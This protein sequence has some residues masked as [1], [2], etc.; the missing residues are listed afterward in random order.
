MN[1][2]QCAGIQEQAFLLQL[3]GATSNRMAVLD[4][5]GTILFVNRSWEEY[6]CRKGSPDPG[7]RV[8]ANYVQAGASSGPFAVHGRTAALGIGRV[9]SG[10]S[11]RFSMEYPCPGSKREQ[12]WFL[13][14]VDGLTLP[15]GS[16]G[17]VVSH[18]DISQ[19][20][21]AEG[22][23]LQ[24]K[25]LLQS[26][27]DAIGDGIL[28][29]DLDLRILSVNRTLR[30]WFHWEEDVRGRR[31]HEAIYGRL[32][33]C[34]SCPSLKAGK[35]GA[36]ETDLK[37]DIPGWFRG[38]L[39]VRSTPL[40]DEQGRVC[41]YVEHLRDV[42]SRKEHED[43][44]HEYARALEGSDELIAAVDRNHVYTMANRAYLRN[45][46]LSPQD[47]VGKS[48]VEVLG[49]ETYEGRVKAELDRAFEGQTVEYE[50]EQPLPES[51]VRHMRVRYYPLT[52]ERGHVE[53]VVGV[54]QDVTERKIAEQA[55]RDRHEL[56]RSLFHK[57][58]SV[59]LLIDPETGVVVDGN[60]AAV[61][62]Y[63]YLPEQLKTLKITDLNI[64]SPD[65]LYEEMQ[66]ARTEKRTHFLFR[67]RLSGGQV[68]DVEVYSGPVIIN[69]RELL[70]SI[71]HDV[72]ERSRAQWE[73]HQ[74]H[75]QLEERV[76]E[77]TRELEKASRAKSEFLA[78]MSHEIRTPIAG[79]LGLTEVALGRDMPK[80]NRGEMVMVR[81]SA[82]SLLHIVNDILD[83]SKIEAR[84]MELDLRNFNL[85]VLLRKIVDRFRHQAREKGLRLIYRY[86]KGL[87]R[88]IHGD[89]DRIEQIV[90]NL[91]S[92]A[93]KFTDQ[94]C[95]SLSVSMARA[96]KRFVDLRVSVADTGIGVP[97]EQQSKLFQ[98]FSQLDHSYSKRHRGAGLG[99]AISKHLAEM[100]GG[101]IEL[102]SRKDKGATFT[103]A[104]R[105]FKGRAEAILPVPRDPAEPEPRRILLA[106]DNPIN[107]V[108]LCRFLE[109]TGHTVETAQNGFEALEKMEQDQFDLVLMDIQMP[110]LDGLETTRL[111]R[112][113]AR[114]GVDPT[115]PII[116]LTAYAMKGDREKFLGAGMNGYVTKPVD[117]ADLNHAIAGIKR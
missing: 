82:Q 11:Q 68:R 63:G 107:R 57:S 74:A 21:Q 7:E 115:V 4:G 64:L 43:R 92:N 113:G 42:T 67:H 35:T 52:G 8:G 33:P 90:S 14:Q 56:Y 16:R 87:P 66:R 75:E 12:Q 28:V 23:V 18:T 80:E 100:M 6:A 106:E 65:Q 5:Q 29:L 112:S 104:A 15:D 69:G 116:A 114:P 108:F 41:G 39:E 70:Y 77:R 60:E 46:A 97:E 96:S 98:S 59:M 38:W 9:L 58:Q 1:H 31:C 20:K 95:V 17:A 85:P 49:V 48:V 45:R 3:L 86:R 53:R 109:K 22:K 89:P 88:M 54:I 93:I 99:L 94:G 117:F 62:Y 110:E 50:M 36:C 19:C 40:K 78:N 84:R 91:L 32:E 105:F 83:L 24:S 76:R 26:G 2:S 72:T 73:L 61:H 47:V 81:E 10:E 111:I 51:R 37:G 103:F 102:H 71:V 79:I 25:A 27:F 13:F 30:E 34:E 101:T 55:L 44:L